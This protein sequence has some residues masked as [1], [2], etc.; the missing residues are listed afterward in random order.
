VLD[1]Y[2]WSDNV[3]Q[4]IGLLEGVVRGSRDE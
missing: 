1:H 4:M 2:V 3:E